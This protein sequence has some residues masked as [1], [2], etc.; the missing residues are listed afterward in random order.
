MTD[1]KP[2][3]TRRGHNEGGIYQ[4]KSDG[5]WVG[6]V[7]LGWEDGKRKRKV[8]YG[9]DRAEVS[10]KV[11]KLLH[12]HQQGLPI[13]TRETRLGDFLDAWLTDSVAPTVRPRTYDSYKSTVD[14]HLKPALGSIMLTKLTQQH[15]LKMMSAKRLE[16]LSERSVAYLR[17]VLRV[18]LHEAMRQ[19]LVHRNVAALVRP[20]K[21]E[22]FEGTAF[23]A[24]EAE[25]FLAHVKSDR[26][27][28]MY[29]TTLVLGLRQAEAFGLRWE[30]LDL[31]EGTLAVRYQLRMVGGT[32]TWVEP[33]SKRSRR[34]VTMPKPLIETLTAHKAAQETERED[35]GDRW[36]DYDLVFTTPIGTA[37][38]GSNVRK[39]F[40]A[41]LEAAK[42][43]P[44]R[45]HDL[46]HT[47]ASLMAARGVPQRTVMEI[48]GHTQAATTAN[49]Y[50]HIATDTM[51]DATD[52]LS[53][54][55]GA[56]KRSS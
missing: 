44:I 56:D 51:R 23:T 5:R 52:R 48:L 34:T 11:T 42:L 36:K 12:D 17:V 15:I 27:G 45:F 10:R 46:R 32:P 26:L 33:K 29:T 40:A 21:F 6:S 8:V 24:K 25:R 54:L 39:H 20:P 2:K 41:Q 18:A 38:D 9:K 4:R 7:H 19:D 37:L 53:D 31:D 22:I 30:N 28:P 55:F 35:A 47:A 16:G 49:I 3:E 14:R 50:T 13:Q 1:E 43:P